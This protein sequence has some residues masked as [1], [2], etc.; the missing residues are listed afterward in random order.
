MSDTSDGKAAAQ[1]VDT[2]FNGVLPTVVSDARDSATPARALMGF[3]LYLFIAKLRAEGVI[4]TRAELARRLNKSPQM[5]SP[6]VDHLVKLGLLSS[7][8]VLG[9]YAVGTQWQIDLVDT[10]MVDGLRPLLAENGCKLSDSDKA[11]V[12]ADGSP[13]DGESVGSSASALIQAG[14]VRP[15]DTN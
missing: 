14:A 5:F 12:L 8:R 13:L 4:V 10:A 11:V 3:S 2:L 15:R 6:Y 7:T 1:L 9:G